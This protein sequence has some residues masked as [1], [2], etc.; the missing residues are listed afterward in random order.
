MPTIEKNRI[1]KRLFIRLDELGILN[2]SV[3]SFSHLI[4][5]FS[6][7]FLLFRLAK[8][9]ALSGELLIWGFALYNCLAFGLEFIIGLFFTERSSKIP[10]VVGMVILMVALVLGQL[11][12]TS[13]LPEYW[14]RESFLTN[15]SSNVLR[16]KTGSLGAFS[17]GLCVLAG[18]GN[19]FFHVGGGVDS[20]SKRRGRYWGSGVFLSFGVL[21]LSL[22]TKL[23]QDLNIDG[24]GLS[25]LAT[26]LS[27]ASIWMLCGSSENKGKRSSNTLGRS[28]HNLRIESRDIPTLEVISW[29]ALLFIVF[30]RSFV[31]FAAVEAWNIR[32]SFLFNG[33]A[34]AFGAF[35]GKFS[36]GFCA[37]FFGAK[38]CGFVSILFSIPCLCIGSRAEIFWT[39]L[40]LLNS[41][42]AI[43]L[44]AL[45][46]NFRLKGFAFGLTTLALLLGYFTYEFFLNALEEQVL[47]IT[48]NIIVIALLVASAFM[49]KYVANLH[50]SYREDTC[51]RRSL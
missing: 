34:L 51:Q 26:G 28:G 12:L 5:D 4:V 24:F 19:A 18:I 9:N 16:Y 6:C 21:G 32:T 31:G 3:Y 20:L 36:G 2:L 25:I 1:W 44:T 27:T 8:I 43:T 35:L 50:E 10:A 48:L 46:R 45:A 49:M 17:L 15:L 23:G 30:S 13:S 41:S 47:A 37:D 39:G 29:L 22:G 38:K 33:S 14:T 7:S 40:V 11:L 42:T